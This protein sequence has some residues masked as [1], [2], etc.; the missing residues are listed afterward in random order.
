M[1]LRGTLTHRKTR[2]LARLLGIPQPCA[3]GVM[4]SLWHVTAEQAPDGAIGRLSNRDIADEIFWEG[5]PEA[6]IAALIEAGWVDECPRH[7]LVIHDWPEHADQTVKRKL[8]RHGRPWARPQLDAA[9]G[10]KAARSL[11][12]PAPGPETEPGSRARAV[13]ALLPEA[14]R[15]HEGL[16]AAAREYDSHASGHRWPAWKPPTLRANAE[17]WAK[18]PPEVLAEALRESVRQNWQGI[19]PEK[20]RG[21]SSQSSYQQAR[22]ALGLEG[23]E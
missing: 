3:L 9:S 8:E 22:S 11:P 10:R 1:A 21:R 19:F 17:A 20:A 12:E 23:G 6:L 4:E 7:R 15:T 2:R 13:I 5:E 14:Y 18:H 16:T